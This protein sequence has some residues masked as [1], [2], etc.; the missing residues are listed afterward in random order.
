MIR[1]NNSG[2]GKRLLPLRKLTRAFPLIPMEITRLATTVPKFL[3]KEVMKEGRLSRPS[4]SS[5]LRTG[6][7]CRPGKRG[8]GRH[9]GGKSEF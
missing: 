7:V 9:D 2:P 1:K 5:G 4:P 8:P 3:E 6:Q